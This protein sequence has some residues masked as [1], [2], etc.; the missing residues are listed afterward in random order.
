M[1]L[2]SDRIADACRQLG[3][4]AIPSVWPV[5]AKHQLAH[6]GSFADF[7]AYIRHIFSGDPS[8]MVSGRQVSI[9]STAHEEALLNLGHDKASRSENAAMP[10]LYLSLRRIETVPPYPL[11]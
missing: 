4:Y 8:G 6:E 9:N 10:V 5:I 1:N 2:Q 7:I 11:I 3:L